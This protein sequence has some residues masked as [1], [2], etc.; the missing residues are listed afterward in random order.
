VAIEAHGDHGRAGYHPSVQE[1][2]LFSVIVTTYDRAEL[3][4][5]ALESVRTQTVED[6]EC[7]VIND[8]GPPVTVPDD[9]R[10]RIIEKANGGFASAV[11]EGLRQARGRYLAF[12]DDDDVFLPNRLEI[13]R[14]GLADAPMAFCWRGQ[15][16]RGTGGYDRLLRGWVH[17][18]IFD[19]PPPLLGQTSIERERAPMLNE[20]I[21]L[22]SEMEWL[23]RATK[24][25]PVSTVPEVGFLFRRDHSDR[26]T[27]DLEIRVRS[28]TKIYDLHREYFATHTKA[29]ARYISRTGVYLWQ[30]GRNKEARQYLWRALVLRPTPR[31][32]FRWGRALV[33][34]R[35]RAPVAVEEGSSA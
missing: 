15:V 22:A 20:D 9:R 1:A 25:V 31:L 6:F 33:M 34:R 8:G 14:R 5:E 19:C 21:R 32:I 10:F 18:V 30:A 11:N 26:T 28:R 17:D 12:L 16:E 24:E 35:P 27:N 4:A 29:A 3:L 23:F 7:L 2:P 13:A